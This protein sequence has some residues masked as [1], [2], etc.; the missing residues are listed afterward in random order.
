MLASLPVSEG[1]P[2]LIFTPEALFA[3]VLFTLR[4]AEIYVP[5]ADDTDARNTP[6]LALAGLQC[7]NSTQSLPST[8]AFGHGRGRKP[9]RIR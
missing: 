4:L 1:L 2:S 8:C 9:T 7:G 5:F 6:G 3:Y